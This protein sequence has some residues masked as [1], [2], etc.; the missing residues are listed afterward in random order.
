M[1]KQPR[2]HAVPG[3]IGALVQ[4]K[5]LRNVGSVKSG[6]AGTRHPDPSLLGRVR[7]SLKLR[8]VS[9]L[10]E[11]KGRRHTPESFCREREEPPKN[12]P[13]FFLSEAK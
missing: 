2:P 4:D 9:S 8:T 6:W 7:P 11:S 10:G 13:S 12:K 1:R 3:G 5:R